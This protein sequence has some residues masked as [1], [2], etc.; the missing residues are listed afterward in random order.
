MR[1]LT[2]LHALFLVSFFPIIINASIIHVPADYATIQAGIDISDDGD[3]VLVERGTYIGLLTFNAHNITLASNYLLSHDTSDVSATV[4]SGWGIEADTVILINHNENNSATLCGFRITDGLTAIY[5]ENADPKIIGNQIG[6]NSHQIDDGNGAGIIWRG[7]IVD[8]ENNTIFNNEARSGAAVY[9]DSAGGYIHHNMIINNRSGYGT[10]IVLRRPNAMSVFNNTICN[11][12]NP[13]YN[14]PTYGALYIDSGLASCTVYN[15]IFAF[16]SGGLGC[17]DSTWIAHSYN[18]F[19]SNSYG[20][21]YNLSQSMGEILVDPS[22]FGGNPW[23]YSINEFSPC[24]NTGDPASPHDPDGS[25][26]DMGALWPPVEYSGYITGTLIDN[27][28]SLPVQG[29]FIRELNSGKQDTSNID[30]NFII[31]PLSRGSYYDISIVHRGFNDSTIYDINVAIDDTTILGAVALQS[32]FSS[33]DYISGDINGDRDAT[34]LADPVYLL[35]YFFGGPLFLPTY[36]CSPQTDFPASADVNGNCTVNGIDASR[37]RSYW[38]GGLASLSHCS[39]CAPPIPDSLRIPDGQ[40]P[41]RSDSI[42]IGNLDLSPIAV[43]AGDTVNIPVWLRND[44]AVPA[45]HITLAIPNIY[46]SQWL[47]GSV[48]YPISNWDSYL[49]CP[50]DTGQ[51][52]TGYTSQ[53]LF[54]WAQISGPPNPN[55]NTI[56][57]YR[58]IAQFSLAFN[59]D[60]DIIGDTTRVIPGFHHLIGTT[61]F[62]DSL[63]LSEWSPAISGG[64]ISIVGI[65]SNIALSRL[66]FVDTISEGFSL[67]EELFIANSGEADLFFNISFDSTWIAITPSEG[68]I[69]GSLT[70]TI[71]IIFNTAHM[72]PGNYNDT[73]RIDSN[74]PDQALIRIPVAI[75]IERGPYGVVEGLVTNAW[76]YEVP[77]TV[78]TAGDEI[79][80]DTTDLDGRYSLGPVTPGNYNIYFTRPRYADTLASNL[81]ISPYDTVSVD[82]M[83]QALPPATIR[84]PE[85]YTTI[86]EGID[87]ALSYYDTVLIAPGVYHESISRLDKNIVVRSRAGQDSTILL[88]VSSEIPIFSISGNVLDLYI[89]GFTFRGSIDTCAVVIANSNCTISNC[90]FDQNQGHY[91]GAIDAL[92]GD[93]LSLYDNIFTNNNA[94]VYG[95]AI[96]AADISLRAV[97]NRFIN[98]AST[99]KGGAVM[100]WNAG[101]SYFENNLFAYNLCGDYGSAISFYDCGYGEL[102]NNT[103]AF[104]TSNL[105]DGSS[106]FLDMAYYL[107]IANNIIS[108]NTGIGLLNAGSAEDPLVIYNDVWGNTENYLYVNPGIGSISESPLFVGG[109][110]YSFHLTSGSPCIDAGNPDDLQDPDATRIDMGAFYFDHVLD[111]CPYMLGDINNSGTPNGIDVTYGVRYFKGGPMPPVTCNNCSEPSPFFAAGDVNG[112]CTFNGIDISYMVSYF[113]GGASLIPCPDCPPLGSAKQRTGIIPGESEPAVM[114]KPRTSA[115]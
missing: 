30:G 2:L 75:V 20:N 18:D 49:F 1:C 50:S 3:T 37:L 6:N 57:G 92:G 36:D 12:S 87:I 4:I 96:F 62:C 73:I 5:I 69:R 93:M 38:T 79:V 26:A 105:Q 55:L 53:S 76:G 22:F 48:R 102:Y 86:Q 89:D 52:F 91:G 94:S 10:A 98:N 100:H 40:D 110:P 67:A 43:L 28:N 51:P 27:I 15:N 72:S 59:P 7:G 24:V 32:G 99:E 29:A 21:F 34:P 47:G 90:T 19:F 83:L 45:L 80:T 81:V 108:Q 114:K 74:D 39:S 60:E 77:G 104:N 56:D 61:A 109:S 101:N 13:Y 64:M 112:S 31:G 85:D 82:M 115:E 11:N 106:I 16:N 41:G 44:E 107:S 63:G 58:K 113:K 111:R 14:I 70:D 103:V 35:N 46:A 23:D 8:I 65:G 97:G 25:R 17:V 84:V 33:L 9:I 88:A 68:N 54:G 42:I 95:G 66:E 78:V 71:S